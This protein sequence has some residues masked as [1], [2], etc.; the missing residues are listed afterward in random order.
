M[1]NIQVRVDD[2]RLRALIARAPGR[3]DDAVAATAFE[4]ERLIKQS[5]GTGSK[6]RTYRRAG[7]SHTASA[8]GSPP[9]VDTGRLRAGI[10]VYRAQ[11]FTQ[12]ISTGDTE[13]AAA[14]EYGTRKMAA[15]PYMTPMAREL[16]RILPERLRGIVE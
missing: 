9:A 2:A 13:Y 8:P 6:G 4:G 11:A 16:E 15:R 7:R 14:L 10:Y 1:A 5:F 3:V 12:V